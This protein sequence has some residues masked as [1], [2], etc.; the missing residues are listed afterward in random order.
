MQPTAKMLPYIAPYATQVCE[1]LSQY[2]GCVMDT[3]G[4]LQRGVSYVRREGHSVPWLVHVEDVETR[5]SLVFV[6]NSVTGVYRCGKLQ[7]WPLYS[8]KPAEFLLSDVLRRLHVPGIVGIVEEFLIDVLPQK[9][10]VYAETHS[11]RRQ[12]LMV[13]DDPAA[14]ATYWIDAT[15]TTTTKNTRRRT[16]Q[17]IWHTRKRICLDEDSKTVHLNRL[18]LNPVVT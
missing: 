7:L 5:E 4:I 17:N 2:G 3:N 12:L 1:L 13:A 11:L 8:L 15:D 18:F 6:L 14:W 16:R 10:P 9:C